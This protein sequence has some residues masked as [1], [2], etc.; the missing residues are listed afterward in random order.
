M[1]LISSFEL[2]LSPHALHEQYDF[3]A[4][5]RVTFDLRKYCQIEQFGYCC[6][7]NIF[8]LIKCFTNNMILIIMLI[9]TQNLSLQNFLLVEQ[10]R[11]L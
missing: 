6:S 9:L 7:S 11:R 2:H 5:V 10:F 8:D 3:D 4:A 1:I